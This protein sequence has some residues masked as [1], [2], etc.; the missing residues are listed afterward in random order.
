MNPEL[1]ARA[2]QDRVAPETEGVFDAPFWR[3]L[4][5]VVNALDNVKARRRAPQSR[6]PQSGAARAR[7]AAARP[8]HPRRPPATRARPPTQDRIPP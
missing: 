5:V 4:D 7:V 2:L 1:H 6:A 3:S 8:S